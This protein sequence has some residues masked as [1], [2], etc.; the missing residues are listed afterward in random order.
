MLKLPWD[1]SYLQEFLNELW[2]THLRG[3]LQQDFLIFIY[4][5]IMTDHI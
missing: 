2:G 3:C 4:I 5:F 1:C